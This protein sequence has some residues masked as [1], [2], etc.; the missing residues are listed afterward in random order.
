MAKV[1][2]KFEIFRVHDLAKTV[3]FRCAPCREM[4]AREETQFMADLP[5]SHLEA[6]TPPFH[7]T[8]CDYFGPYK[9]KISRNKTAKYY[10]VIFMCLNSKAVHLELAVD[11]STMEFM[12]TLR[13]CFATRGQPA[14]MLSDNGSQLVGGEHKLREMIRGW[15]VE[16]LKGFNAEKGM[17]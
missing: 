5:R 11:Y 14:M 7:F 3:K 10:G 9:V 2:K 8:A 17:K 6:F 13:R 16:Q 12:K 4:E 15:D 1:R